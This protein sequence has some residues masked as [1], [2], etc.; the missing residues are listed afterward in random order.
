MSLSSSRAQHCKAAS[1]LLGSRHT[2]VAEGP[3]GLRRGGAQ[4]GGGGCAGR[5]P[6]H[7]K[8]IS[9]Y[10]YGRSPH[11][12]G[13]GVSFTRFLAGLCA[14]VFVVGVSLFELTVGGSVDGVFRKPFYRA[15]QT[16]VGYWGC[17]GSKK[18]DVGVLVVSSFGASV[19]GFQ[20]CFGLRLLTR[21]WIIRLQ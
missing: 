5:L 20:K 13:W 12:A 8:R 6:A 14:R 16:C 7:C 10:V 1:A 4:V 3:K 9:I 15:L 11:Q 19:S 21:V 17:H 2:N 18:T